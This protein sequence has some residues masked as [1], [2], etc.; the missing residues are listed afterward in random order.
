MS[1][2]SKGGMTGIHIE[3]LLRIEL[4]KSGCGGLPNQDIQISVSNGTVGYITSLV[5]WLDEIGLAI[6]LPG[7][8][9]NAPFSAYIHLSK[10]GVE[11]VGLQVRRG[12]VW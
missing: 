6:H 2:L 11:D 10:K 7:L 3:N 8:I 4:E 12:Q 9:Y 1:G 5:E